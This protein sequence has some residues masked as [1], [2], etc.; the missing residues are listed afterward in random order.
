MLGRLTWINAMVRDV[1]L[2][3]LLSQRI[4][5]RLTEAT[6]WIALIACAV[7]PVIGGGLWAH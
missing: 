4:R 7:A 6:R 2:M 5:M 3:V 1:C